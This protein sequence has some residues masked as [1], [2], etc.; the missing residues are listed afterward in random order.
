MVL[1]VESNHD[2]LVV[3]RGYNVVTMEGERMSDPPNRQNE[4]HIQ[5][6]S[7]FSLF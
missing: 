7:K 3:V 2:V 5:K 6:H 4:N 1:L